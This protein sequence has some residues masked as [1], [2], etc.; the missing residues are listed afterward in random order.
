VRRL[1]IA[2][3]LLLVFAAPARA[4]WNDDAEKCAE[5]ST[6]DLALARCTRAIQSGELSE[7][8]LVVTLNNR[9]NAYQN[10][11][12]YARAIADYDQAIRLNSESA[13]LF[14]N[15]GSA[16][17]HR[18]DYERAIQDYEQAIR[19]DPTSARAI[20]SR[21]RVNHLKGNY[22]QA[23]KD[24]DE[25]IVLDPDYQ[26]A[27][28]N[29]AFARFDQGLFTASVPDFARAVQLDPSR[30]YRVLGLYL[31]KARAGA[32]DRKG[33]ANNAAQLN[34]TRWPGP[35]V[36]LFLGLIS[37]QALIA[38]AQDPDPTMQRERHC[39][40]Y[41]YAGEFYLIRGQRAAAVQMFQSAVATGVT[42]LFEHSSAKGE[43]G[44]LGGTGRRRMVARP[45]QHPR[46]RNVSATQVRT[47]VPRPASVDAR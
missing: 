38:A 16:Y 15:R 35:V 42:S 25:A 12:D 17:Q 3:A 22:E 14:Y 44:R 28:Y 10:K 5:T 1:L 40:A 45:P 7:P 8:S 46:D 24:Y 33:L 21:G 26:L 20:T 37:P 19:L 13:L 4:Q 18:G 41:F 11:G 23:I 29:R 47:A 43:L 34:L 30:T 39:E 6:P 2:S 27:F 36:A 31:A 9:G 32:V